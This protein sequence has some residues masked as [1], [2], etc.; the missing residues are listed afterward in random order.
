MTGRQ[1]TF[2]LSGARHK[3]DRHLFH[4]RNINSRKG[5]DNKVKRSNWG[6]GMLSNHVLKPSRL[7]TEWTWA[8]SLPSI[9]IFGPIGNG[10]Y[11]HTRTH[12]V[13]ENKSAQNR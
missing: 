10:Q 9:S 4:Y 7:R 13:S 11:I 2:P 1:I 12:T 6:T 8:G 5:K 3:S